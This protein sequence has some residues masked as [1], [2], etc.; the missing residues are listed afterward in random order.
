MAVKV[1]Q[2]HTIIP[3]HPDADASTNPAPHVAPKHATSPAESG[4]VFVDKTSGAD[5]R[6]A[7]WQTLLGGGKRPPVA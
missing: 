5:E 4:T 2:R 3:R 1:D 7:A 6:V